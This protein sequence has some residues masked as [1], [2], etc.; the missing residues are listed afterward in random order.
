MDSDE[1][2]QLFLIKNFKNIKRQNEGYWRDT[3]FMPIL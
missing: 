1:F 3:Y 2:F